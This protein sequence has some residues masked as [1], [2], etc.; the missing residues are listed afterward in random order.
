MKAK[1]FKPGDIYEACNCH[2]V[3][4][5]EVSYKLNCISGISLIDGHY[6]NGCSLT[7]CGVRK[8]TLKQALKI[9]TEGPEEI[10]AKNFPPKQKWWKN[11]HTI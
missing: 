3:L 8:L 10:W 11:E 1:R 7:H 9:K 5:T 2:P 4:C 6:G